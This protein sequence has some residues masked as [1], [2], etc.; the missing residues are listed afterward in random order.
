MLTELMLKSVLALASAPEGA[1]GAGDNTVILMLFYGGLFA[2]F[3]FF[4]IRPQTKKTNETHQMQAGISKGDTVIT[5][6]G[7]YGTVYKTKDDTLVLQIAENVRVKCQRSAV[8]E[9]VGKASE[10]KKS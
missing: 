4:L 6:G 8:L 1:P 3:Y 7:I 5:S 2:V 10:P 9:R